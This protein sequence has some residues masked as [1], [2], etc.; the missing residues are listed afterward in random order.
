[1]VNEMFTKD[2][3]GGSHGTVHSHLQRTLWSRN[4]WHLFNVF[5]VS[6]LAGYLEK[7]CKQSFDLRPVAA[8][9]TALPALPAITCNL[10]DYRVAEGGGTESAAAAAGSSSTDPATGTDASNAVK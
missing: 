1:M 8:G 5:T 6:F 2:H 10:S 3:T 4:S 9:R 7:H